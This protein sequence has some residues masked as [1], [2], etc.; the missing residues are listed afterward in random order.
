MPQKRLR[1]DI[2]MD[3]SVVLR[4][5]HAGTNAWNGNEWSR[6]SS[7]EPLDC[8]GDGGPD[9][10][11]RAC[12]DASHSRAADVA[13]SVSINAPNWKKPPGQ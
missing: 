5:K 7:V 13:A 6:N 10:L 2:D 12:L 4:D 11:F 3:A 9:V 8:C 1:L